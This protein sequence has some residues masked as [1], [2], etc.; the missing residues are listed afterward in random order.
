MTDQARLEKLETRNA[1]QDDVISQLSEQIY[2]HQK[3]I[4]R[5]EHLVETLEQKLRG[6]A[7]GEQAPLPE[8]ERAP[9]Y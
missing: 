6:L 3:Q 9:H 2:G 8:H 4:D 5:L 7:S 1:Y